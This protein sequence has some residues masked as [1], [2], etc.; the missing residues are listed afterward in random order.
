MTVHMPKNEVDELGIESGD[1][2]LVDLK[3]AK[4]FVEDYA[5]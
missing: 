5:I 2:V 4:V 3:D 1:R